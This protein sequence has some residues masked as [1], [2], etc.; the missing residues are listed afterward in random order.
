MSDLHAAVGEHIGS[1]DSILG[2]LR[3]TTSSDARE[4]LHQELARA[5]VAL[6][7]AHVAEAKAIEAKKAAEAHAAEAK[8]AAEAH[9]AEAKADEPAEA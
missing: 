1:L 3:A 9:A 7:Q 4:T 5:M 8:K 6:K 2:R